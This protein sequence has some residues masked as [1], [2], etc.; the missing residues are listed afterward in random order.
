MFSWILPVFVLTAHYMGNS[1]SR[2]SCLISACVNGNDDICSEPHHSYRGNHRRVAIFSTGWRVVSIGITPLIAISTAVVSVCGAAYGAGL[3]RKAEEGHLY[4]IRLGVIISLFV[5]VSVYLCAP[6]IAQVFTYS[7][8]AAHLYPGLVSFLQTVCLFFPAVSFG[9]FSASLLQGFGRG[10]DSLVITVIRTIVM[11][12]IS[13]YLL[14]VTFG[15]GIMGIWWGLVIGNSVG[16]GIGYVWARFYTKK[17]IRETGLLE[18][19]V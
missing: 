7:E 2:Y 10:F 11:T 1:E 9:I 12:V 3:I 16:A 6:Y 19:S 4:A 18:E 14:A 5:T 15:W 8:G 17:L 13:C